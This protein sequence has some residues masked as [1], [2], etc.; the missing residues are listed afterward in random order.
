VSLAD[1]ARHELEIAQMSGSPARPL[2][3]QAQLAKFRRNWASGAAPLPEAAAERLV[4]LVDTLEA[5]DDVRELVD[6]A[7]APAS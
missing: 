5:V 1:G 2:S 6:L 7:C 3:R 4:R